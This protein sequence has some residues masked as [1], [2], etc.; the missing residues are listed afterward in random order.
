MLVEV[1]K[2]LLVFALNVVLHIK[3][4][5]RHIWSLTE[6]VYRCVIDSLYFSKDLFT[7]LCFP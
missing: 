2:N 6:T 1:S 7:K 5:C 3:Y 4:F